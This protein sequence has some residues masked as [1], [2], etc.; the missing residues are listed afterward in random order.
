M[1][2]EKKRRT[3]IGVGIGIV[4]QSV[5]QVLQ[6]E[7]PSTAP[8]GFLLTTVGLVLFVWGCFNYAQG[9]GYS[10]WLGLLGLLSCIGLI[11]L[12]VLP[13]RHKTV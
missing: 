8:I 11:V 7:E 1:I 2:A 4:L 3:N 5:G 9:K 12:V 6:N 13:D 10:Q